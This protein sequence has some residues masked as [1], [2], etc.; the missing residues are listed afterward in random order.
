MK[1]IYCLEEKDADEFSRDHVIPVSF[2]TFNN[3]LT[4]VNM[5]C[6]ECNRELGKYVEFYLGKAT[7]EGMMRYDFNIKNPEDLKGKP[8]IS[9]LT[10]K[11]AEGKW[12]G[13]YAKRTFNSQLNKI[14]ILPFPQIGF[15]KRGV[16]RYDFYPLWEI[17]SKEELDEAIYDIDSSRG[18]IILG[19][20]LKDAM[21]R[22]DKKGFKIKFREDS[23][24]YISKSNEDIEC[25]T[26]WSINET[27]RR[28]IAKIALNYL[29]NCQG[30]GFVLNE[31]FNDIRE[32]IRWANKP[33]HPIFIMDDR[34]ILA[35]E[36]QG[37]KSRLGHIITLNWASDDNSIIA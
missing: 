12:K 36:P 6:E 13:A 19:C 22:L 32:F 28:N 21:K 25:V 26:E 1:C 9:N 20:K 10:I 37:G 18:F 5:V 34:P 3:N 27:V 35:D 15:K 14:T 24:D 33:D 2:G 16:E 23:Y 30:V 8:Y 17:P 31:K 7:Y 11:V 29:A 4:L